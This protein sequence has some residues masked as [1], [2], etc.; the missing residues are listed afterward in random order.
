MSLKQTIFH[1][2]SVKNTS[3]KYKP[4]FNHCPETKHIFHIQAM[5]RQM[6]QYDKIGNVILVNDLSDFKSVQ[7]KLSHRIYNLLLSHYNTDNCFYYQKQTNRLQYLM[8]DSSDLISANYNDETKTWNINLSE[9]KFSY[10]DSNDKVISNQYGFFI[11]NPYSVFALAQADIKNRNYLIKCGINNLFSE[12]TSVDN[13]TY[14]HNVVKLNTTDLNTSDI[15]TANKH[16]L[17]KIPAI[18]ITKLNLNSDNKKLKTKSIKFNTNSDFKSDTWDKYGFFGISIFNLLN[19]IQK[20]VIQK[21]KIDHLDCNY[22]QQNI[23]LIASYVLRH[24][25]ERLFTD[26][27][28]LNLKQMKKKNNTDINL[29]NAEI[30]NRKINDDTIKVLIYTLLSEINISFKNVKLYYAYINKQDVILKIKPAKIYN[31]YTNSLF[32]ISKKKYVADLN[33][34]LNQSIY[35]ARQMK[36]KYNYW[37]LSASDFKLAETYLKKLYFNHWNVDES[38]LLPAML[39]YFNSHFH[40]SDFKSVEKY[41]QKENEPTDKHGYSELLPVSS[42]IIANLMSDLADKFYADCLENKSI[43]ELNSVGI[44]A[45][46]MQLIYMK[47]IRKIADCEI[48][49]GYSSKNN[50][51]INDIETGFKAVKALLLKNE[52]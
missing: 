11:A 16:Q 44:D 37:Y 22:R 3:D 27:E 7:K 24:L 19:L 38:K 25:P 45:D 48:R 40:N 42:V 36:N 15:I 21:E 47:A 31:D 2:F 12:F 18:I 30:K 35:Y 28:K 52:Y 23:G 17:E 20:E 13:A 34:G 26:D 49:T 41:S 51:T 33:Q 8:P 1:L 4:E 32:K 46:E 6:K 14:L 43:T 50:Y 29:Y 10:V 39:F 9:N 5:E